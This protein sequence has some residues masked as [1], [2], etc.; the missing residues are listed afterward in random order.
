VCPL[1]IGRRPVHTARVL[2]LVALLVLLPPVVLFV[3]RR[4]RRPVVGALLAIDLLC[5]VAWYLAL[6]ANM[7]TADETGGPGSLL[8]GVGWLIGA[9]VAAVGSVLEARGQGRGRPAGS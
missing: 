2:E 1:P 4:G 5:L 6:A 3:D 8:A 7:S 9:A